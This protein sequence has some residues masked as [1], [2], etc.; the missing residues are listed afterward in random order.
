MQW[1]SKPGIL[2]S[3]FDACIKSR[4]ISFVSGVIE[5][6]QILVSSTIS[7][8]NSLIFISIIHDTIY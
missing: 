8:L 1:R 4:K 3:A 6:Y 2:A 7:V 5:I